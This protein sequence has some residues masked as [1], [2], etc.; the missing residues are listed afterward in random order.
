LTFSKKYYIFIFTKNFKH[1]SFDCIH[2]KK[3]L[4]PLGLA[5]KIAKK[6]GEEKK[7]ASLKNYSAN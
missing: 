3:K 2:L 4:H 1:L 6:T 5:V 7:Q